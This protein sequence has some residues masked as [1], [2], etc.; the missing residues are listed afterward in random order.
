MSSQGDVEIQLGGEPVT[1][2]CTL[3]AAKAVNS[4][5]GNFVAANRA[6]TEIALDAMVVVI[7]AGLGAKRD[8]EFEEKVFASGLLDLNPPVKRYLDLLANNGR[9][10]VAPTEPAAPGNE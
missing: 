5:F 4:Y 6:V 1:L 10:Y 3:G 2:R 8:A 9:P 7:A